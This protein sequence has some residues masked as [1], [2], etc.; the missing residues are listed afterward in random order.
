MHC[1]AGRLK[2]SSG[3]GQG[4]PF[5][6]AFRCEKYT[7]IT[8]PHLARKMTAAAPSSRKTIRPHRKSRAGCS[9]CKRRKVKV[10]RVL[11]SFPSPLSIGYPLDNSMTLHLVL[12]MLWLSASL[13]LAACIVVR[14][15]WSL[16][17]IIHQCN[18][19]KPCSNCVN[20]GL[21]CDLVSDGGR[22]E[23]GPVS[24]PRRGRGRPRKIWTGE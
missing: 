7:A 16:T 24:V 12:V 5:I 8:S 13:L 19:E 3:L 23:D 6:F 22:A 11:N 2:I 1:G 9:L 4:L 21:P 15:A 10:S 20:F 17:D 18:E 14:L